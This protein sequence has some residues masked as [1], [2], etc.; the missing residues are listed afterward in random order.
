MTSLWFYMHSSLS[1]ETSRPIACN[2]RLHC[3]RRGNATHDA[4]KGKEQTVDVL[5]DRYLRDNRPFHLIYPVL[6]VS[7]GYRF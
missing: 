2:R 3:R 4:F 6:R 7:L 1:N 5:F